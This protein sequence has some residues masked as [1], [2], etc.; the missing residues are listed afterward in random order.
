MDFGEEKVTL[1]LVEIE[2]PSFSRSAFGLVPN[3]FS[4]FLA[5]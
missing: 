1:R 2:L 3:D 5:T 4:L